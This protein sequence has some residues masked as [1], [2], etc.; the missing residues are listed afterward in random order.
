MR[1]EAAEQ[2]AAAKVESAQRSL[3]SLCRQLGRLEAKAE[4]TE[5]ENTDCAVLVATI[6]RLNRLVRGIPSDAG[7]VDKVVDTKIMNTGRRYEGMPVLV[8]GK[9]MH[10]GFQ[11]TVISD[12]DNAAR[13][14]RL[15]KKRR[16]GEDSWHD[17]DQDGIVV[18]IK[19]E[20]GHSTVD[21][22]VDKCLHR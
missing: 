8:A 9:G 15:A 13:V 7:S 14:R 20:M 4:R 12:H 5:T 21:V 1:D 18:T 19:S 11:G 3:P 2:M 16:K 17:E 22:T 10:K 6:M